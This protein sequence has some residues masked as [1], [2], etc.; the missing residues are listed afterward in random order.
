MPP[1]PSL[2][3]RPTPIQ[4]FVSLYIH[5]LNPHSSILIHQ[6][7]L[8]CLLSSCGHNLCST[9]PSTH[10]PL[11]IHLLICI[12]IHLTSIFIHQPTYSITVSV[13]YPIVNTTSVTT[14]HSFNHSLTHTP[15]FIH[16]LVCIFIHL[17]SLPIAI[18]VTLNHQGR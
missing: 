9:H 8:V 16:L 14:I 6:P 1:I 7:S 17:R 15:L 10:S 11:F 12:F 18:T 13:C 2:T 5:P 4:S 3:H